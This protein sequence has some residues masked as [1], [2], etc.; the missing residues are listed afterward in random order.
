V[1]Q[2]FN[3]FFIAIQVRYMCST[4]GCK[5]FEAFSDDLDNTLYDNDLLVIKRST[6]TVRAVELLTGIEK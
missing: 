5:Y 2:A 4:A 1:E 3:C 6:K